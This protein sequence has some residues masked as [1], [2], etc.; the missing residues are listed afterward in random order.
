MATY[1]SI[2]R[3]LNR[4][5]HPYQKEINRFPLI[6]AT[7]IFLTLLALIAFSWRSAEKAIEEDRRNKVTTFDAIVENSL[8][9]RL[10]A[11]ED[12][13]YGASGFVTASQPYPAKH[14]WETYIN[15]LHL[16]DRYPSI[17]AIAF[18]PIIQ[19]SA[20]PEFTAVAANLGVTNYVPSPL[21][22]DPR[23]I[24][25]LYSTSFKNPD[26]ITSSGS[27][28]NLL[29]DPNRKAAIE[30][31]ITSG[32]A[33]LT[34]QLTL[35]GDKGNPEPPP[36]ALLYLPVYK[37]GAIIDTPEKRKSSA[38]GVDFIAFRLQELFDV[39][40][41][42]YDLNY[43][44]VV[45]SMATGAPAEIYRSPSLTRAGNKLKHEYTKEI[46]LNGQKWSFTFY[47][48]DAVVQESIRNRPSGIIVGGTIFALS[49]AVSVYLLVR[50]RILDQAYLEDMKLQTVKDDLLSL[51][52]HQLRTPATGVKQYVGML[53]QGYVG[54]VST[55]QKEMLT[56]AYESNE[57]QLRIINEF[58][59]MAKADAGR[60]IVS[61]QPFD[62]TA[63]VKEVVKEQKLEAKQA[64]ITVRQKLEPNVVVIGD[65]HSIRMVVENLINNAI[66]YTPAGG[67]IQVNLYSGTRNAILN[68][69]DTGVGIDESDY[70][71]LFKQFSRIPNKLSQTT[72]G[73]GIGLYLAQHLATLNKGS[74]S[75]QSVPD[76]GSTFTAKFKV[77]T[78]RN[79]TSKKKPARG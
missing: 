74:I 22:E 20:I 3:W 17:Y 50:R 29:S 35:V 71:L 56:R 11:Y 37:S 52:S 23:V 44:Y 68:V 30:N 39:N 65:P 21:T 33:T 57:R 28:F 48:S 63:L 69:A 19:K 43:G 26:S 66:K 31:T 41:Q 16:D 72:S 73:S 2:K 34:S 9:Q 55:E 61:P 27:G 24:P 32:R 10:S 54:K 45:S 59:Y 49:I 5:K 18:A 51:A 58:L 13:L 8:S 42:T 60:I 46:E 14:N 64:Q 75:Y 67:K 47:A 7:V 62:F 4:P 1:N 76:Q 12:V 25:T 38:L 36:S 53:L 15:S 78:V 6:P 40:D 70:H 79:L 77:E